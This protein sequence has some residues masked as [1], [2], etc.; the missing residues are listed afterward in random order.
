M[1]FNHRCTCSPVLTEMSLCS[2]YLYRGRS[3]M[4]FCFNTT[5]I[6]TPLYKFMW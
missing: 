1:I 6:F 4:R 5:C 2:W 3:C